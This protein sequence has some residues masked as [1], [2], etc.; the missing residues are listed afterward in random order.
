EHSFLL[1]C[2]PLFCILFEVSVKLGEVQLD[3]SFL[4]RG[5]G[6]FCV[7]DSTEKSPFIPLYKRGK[8]DIW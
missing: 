2:I 7:I 4:K 1:H 6:R 3:P 5:K 8:L